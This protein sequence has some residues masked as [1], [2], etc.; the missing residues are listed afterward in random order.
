[1]VVQ[2][3]RQCPEYQKFGTQYLGL[4]ETVTHSLGANKNYRHGPPSSYRKVGSTPGCTVKQLKRYENKPHVLLMNVVAN[5]VLPCL[6]VLPI[7]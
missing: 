7:L 3:M 1:M 4:L 2:N 5:P 6:P